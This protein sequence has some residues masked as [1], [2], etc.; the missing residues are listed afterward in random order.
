MSNKYI[1]AVGRRNRST[2]NVKL[3]PNGS[4]S[5]TIIKPNGSSIDL[6]S[7]FGGNEYLYENAIYPFLVMGKDALSSYDAEI[8]ISGGGPKGHSDSIKLAFSRSII[9]SDAALR[10]TLKPFG[11][12]KRDPRRKERVKPGLRG[13]R[14]RPQW[15]KR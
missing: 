11:L 14:K 15:S 12:L 5:F 4:G 2:V 13:A 3:Y 10:T 1:F 8:E 7:Y 6:K 9:S